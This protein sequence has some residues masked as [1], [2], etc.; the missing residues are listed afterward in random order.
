[1]EVVISDISM[2]TFLGWKPSDF[3]GSFSPG[4]RLD[5]VEKWLK[6]YGEFLPRILLP[7]SG[8]FP[9]RSDGIL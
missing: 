8:V 2:N 6:N 9:A 7:F 4:F 3:F 5:L 1:M